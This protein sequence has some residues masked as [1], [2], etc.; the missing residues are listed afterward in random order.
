MGLGSGIIVLIRNPHPDVKTLGRTEVARGWGITLKT[1]N[2]LI[3]WCHDSFF[4]FLCTALL[5]GDY[6]S[7][8]FLPLV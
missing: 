7:C 5:C 8:S 4:L 1:I 3:E 6:F 2:S